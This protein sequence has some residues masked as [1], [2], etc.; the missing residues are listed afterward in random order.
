M[1]LN[2]GG[3]RLQIPRF[4]ANLGL[5]GVLVCTSPPQRQPDMRRGAVYSRVH[6]TL[7]A[8]LPAVRKRGNHDA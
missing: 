5:V 7:A 2:T 3:L 4:C 6:R 8:R 1:M